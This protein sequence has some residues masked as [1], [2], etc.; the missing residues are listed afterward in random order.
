[1]YDTDIIESLPQEAVMIPRGTIVKILNP[2]WKED[3]PSTNFEVEIEFIKTYCMWT[4]S[5]SE[6]LKGVRI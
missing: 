5:S 3:D 2:N 6:R 4:S 1:M